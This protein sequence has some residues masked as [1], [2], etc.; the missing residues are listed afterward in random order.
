MLD[1]T[2]DAVLIIT[3]LELTPAVA[4]IRTQIKS[5]LAERC[6]GDRIVLQ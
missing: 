2:V 6:P 5:G 1:D 3:E 4:D